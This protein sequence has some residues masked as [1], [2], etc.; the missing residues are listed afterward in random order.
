[1][2]SRLLGFEETG[3]VRY[4]EWYLQNPWPAFILLA[5]VVAAAGLVVFLYRQERGLPR[6]RRIL[7]GV[8]R[9]VLYAVILLLLFEP[10]LALEMT[11]RLRRNFLVLLDVSQSMA[12]QDPR[13]SRESLADAAMCLGEVE[14]GAE[15]P[16]VSEEQKRRLQAV[17]RLELAKGLLRRRQANLFRELAEQHRVRYFC[18]G[19]RLEPTSGEGEVEEGSLARAA[20]EAKATQLGTAL[21]EAVARYSGQPIAGIILLTDGASNEGLEPTEAARRLGERR[22]P[23]FPIGLGLP[24]P[25]DI[26]VRDVVVP[27]TVFCRDSVS[28]RVQLRSAGYKGRSVDVVARLGEQEVARERVVLAGKTQYVEFSFTPEVA[29][30]EVALEVAVTPVEGET[31]RDNNRVRKSLRVV[32]EKIKVIYVEGKPR[33]E[34]RY[35]RA[36][37]LR[38]HRLDVKFVMTQGDRDLP[39]ASAQYLSQFPERAEQA[40]DFDL[41][42]LGDVPA[43]VFAPRQ[44][45]RMEQLVRERGGS[46]LMLAG[47]RHAPVSYLGTPIAAALP[48]RLLPD[49]A[50]PVDDLVH[51]LV[52]E[53]GGENAV[54]SLA[55]DPERN[56]EL[57]AL[58][59]PLYRLPRLD[60]AKPG[61]TVLAE[62]SESTRGERYPLV[63][64]QRYGTGKTLFVGTDQL[65]RLR[66]KRGDTHHARFWRRTVQFLALSRLLGE[67]KR[68]H[69]ATDR[70]EYRTGQRIQIYANV[71]N[72]SFEPVDA[73]AYSIHVAE[74]AGGR[75]ARPVRLKP[76]PGSPG[77][78]EGFSTVTEAGRYRITPPALD[79]KLANAPEFTVKEGALEQVEPAMQEETL[80]EMAELSGGRFFPVRELPT[81][82]RSVGG[83][84]QTTVI[85]RNKELWDL[86]VVFLL[87]LGCAGTEW[88]FRRKHNLV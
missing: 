61:A 88:Y 69:L 26:A 32:D 10:I 47:H 17:S 12:I 28:T 82:P 21:E 60:G 54:M 72:E 73:P 65:W 63:A 23:L 29:A 51:P 80:R 25:P 83:T 11:V 44:L 79:E 40:F 22:I 16:M 27:E 58:V 55:P 86:P 1:M 5:L 87:L 46:L 84:E 50:A 38:D 64:W 30:D 49:Q 45:A 75:T 20:A 56:Q 35:L 31:S 6:G 66:F 24:D 78:Y 67:N 43:S 76:V 8:C 62:L 9:F 57:W 77:L 81:L 53:A 15:V 37:L 4:F 33:W 52:A 70:R 71:L 14:F 2:L 36:V 3:P 48:V 13:N 18:F 85:R 74:T 19:E 68:V 59:R 7:L 34:Y 39:R 42:I 41:I